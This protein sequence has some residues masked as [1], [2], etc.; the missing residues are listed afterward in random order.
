MKQYLIEEQLER[1]QEEIEGFNLSKPV[2]EMTDEEV[3]D[4]EAEASKFVEWVECEGF[5]QA[6][7]KDK[8]TGKLVL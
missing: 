4:A 1:I 2:E 8:K 5:A 7:P 3:R 6:V